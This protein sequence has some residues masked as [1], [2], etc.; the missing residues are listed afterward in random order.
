MLEGYTRENWEEDSGSS[1][2]D[3][4]KSGSSMASHTI[5]CVGFEDSESDSVMSVGDWFQIP[6]VA[7]PSYLYYRHILFFGPGSGNKRTWIEFR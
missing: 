7:Y 6:K 1:D 2:E 3:Q 5:E 4:W